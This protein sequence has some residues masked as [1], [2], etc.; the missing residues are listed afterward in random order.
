MEE[1]IDLSKNLDNCNGIEKDLTPL[2]ETL[3]QAVQEA[4]PQL[5][6][7]K[8]INKVHREIKRLIAEKRKARY[9]MASNPS[10]TR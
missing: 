4:T 10:S 7:Q 3:K 1:K 9:E 5:E 2:T 8:E 6:P